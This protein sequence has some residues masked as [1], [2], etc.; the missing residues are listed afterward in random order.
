MLN[1][2]IIMNELRYANNLAVRFVAEKQKSDLSLG[3][4]NNLKL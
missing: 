4:D 3:E 2:R 1:I